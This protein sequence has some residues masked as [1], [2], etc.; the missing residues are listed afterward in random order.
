M[1][2]V[3]AKAASVQAGSWGCI[4]AISGGKQDETWERLL[5]R[6]QHKQLGSQH[7]KSEQRAAEPLSTVTAQLVPSPW[8]AG[9][10]DGSCGAPAGSQLLARAQVERPGLELSQLPGQLVFTAALNICLGGGENPGAAQSGS[11]LSPSAGVWLHRRGS[12]NEGRAPSGV[13]C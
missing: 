9:E 1:Q 6:S 7:W 5:V 13:S 12:A 3:S 10:A 2:R 11:L 4:R 8:V